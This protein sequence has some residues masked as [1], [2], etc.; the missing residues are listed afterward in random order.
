MHPFYGLTHKKMPFL[1][2]KTHLPHHLY[3]CF[4]ITANHLRLL[5]MPATLL[6]VLFWNKK[7]PLDDRT[8]LPS[9]QNHFS[10]PNEITKSMIKNYSPLF[11]PLNISDT[12]CRVI[13]TSHTSTPT[14]QTC[15][16]L[17]QNKHSLDDKP[18]GPCFWL[19][20]ITSLS[21]NP[22]KLIKPMDCP[23]VQIIKRG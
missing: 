17:P 23:G 2:Y 6:Q 14:M 1:D 7:T 18:A 9:F 22:A 20:S 5:Q 16:T 11:W 4:P 21:P 8:L 3:Y 15:D 10:W 13:L 12:T 19:P